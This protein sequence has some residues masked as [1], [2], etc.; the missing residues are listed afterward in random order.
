MSHDHTQPDP[1]ATR[2]GRGNGAG[3]SAG[4]GSSGSK[5]KRSWWRA[6][7]R[8]WIKRVVWTVVGFL[9]LGLVRLPAPASPAR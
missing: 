1:R 2:S 9:A 5:A 4:T 6:P 7:R 3:T 8:T